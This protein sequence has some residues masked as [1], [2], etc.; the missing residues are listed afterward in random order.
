MSYFTAHESRQQVPRLQPIFTANTRRIPKRCAHLRILMWH[1]LTSVVNLPPPPLKR[2]AA[3]H[4]PLVTSAGGGL[5]EGGGG[6]CR[7][8]GRHGSRVDLL[9]S[10]P[11]PNQR[12]RSARAGPGR[13]GAAVF[14]WRP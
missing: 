7:S 4:P 5:K 13:I 10:R 1:G 3:P 12:T 2:P 8:T 14:T 9:P 11:V 6:R